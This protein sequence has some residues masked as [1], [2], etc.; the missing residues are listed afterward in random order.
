MFDKANWPSSCANHMAAFSG[1][2]VGTRIST[3]L[4]VK[5]E[6]DGCSGRVDGSA[7]CCM[8][9]S[10]GHQCGGIGVNFLTYTIHTHT[11]NCMCTQ[12]YF[13]AYVHCLCRPLADCCNESRHTLTLLC[14][15]HFIRKYASMFIRLRC[16]DDKISWVGGWATHWCPPQA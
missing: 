11:H 9:C 16:I 1:H 2:K 5:V 15:C 6:S 4:V 8:M 3:R 10:R 7:F 14:G 13:S 12:H